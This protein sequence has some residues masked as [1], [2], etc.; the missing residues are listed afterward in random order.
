MFVQI[1]RQQRGPEGE[2]ALDSS[3]EAQPEL[4]VALG[5]PHQE[6]QTLGTSS[7]HFLLLLLLLV[8]CLGHA[9]W[10]KPRARAQGFFFSLPKHFSHTVHI[11]RAMRFRNVPFFGRPLGKKREREFQKR[12]KEKQT[13]RTSSWLQTLP[14]SHWLRPAASP[15]LEEEAAR[16][17]SE[18]LG[19]F[20]V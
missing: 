20:S 17:L 2:K 18:R 3:A 13:L 12:K 8:L 4:C 5:A 19:N 16:I 10:P 14:S 9:L 15:S 11:C 6:G 1:T 7:F